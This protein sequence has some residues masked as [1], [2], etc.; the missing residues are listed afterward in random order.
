MRLD[1]IDLNLFVVFEALYRER[2]VTRVAAQLNLTQPAVSNKLA[3]LR[4]TF[5][6]TLFVRSPEG[7]TPTPV[8]DNIIGDVR[9]ALDLMRRSVGS[10]TRFDPARSEKTFRLGM[11]DL[12]EFL[13][14]PRLHEMIHREAPNI[15]ITSYYV[16]RE[17]ATEDLKAGQIDL[18]LDAPAVNARELFQKQL[19][20]FPYVV[21]MRTGHPLARGKLSL[22]RYLAAEHLH[23]SSRRKGRGHV[24]I[25]LNKVGKQRHIAMRVQNYLVAA[26]IVQETGLVWTVPRV[27]ADAL[28]MKPREL[29]FDVEPLAWNLYWPRG[30]EDDPANRWMRQH[31]AAT[32]DQLKP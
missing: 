26:K 16:A 22:E 9:K 1:K 15:A 8:A 31:L 3:R 2:N 6:D 12:A 29:P 24:D 13:L 5:D 18:L 21:T 27:L 30:A 19:M 14:L 32:V 11:N 20:A 23:V 25:A 7:M 4:E 17:T 10:N 28:S